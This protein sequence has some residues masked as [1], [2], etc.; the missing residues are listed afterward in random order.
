MIVSFQVQIYIFKDIINTNAEV[1]IILNTNY[2]LIQTSP[3]DVELSMQ[4][5]YFEDKLI[6]QMLLL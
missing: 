1:Y 3:A 5:F 4:K 2:H 6:L